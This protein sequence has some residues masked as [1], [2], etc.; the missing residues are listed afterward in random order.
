MACPQLE[1]F[2]TEWQAY[3]DQFVLYFEPGNR[4]FNL[5][6]LSFLFVALKARLT[7]VEKDDKVEYG[8]LDERL[9]TQGTSQPPT[10]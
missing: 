6:N 3:A 4:K 10:L 7:F 1:V 5:W 8:I 9:W 2:D